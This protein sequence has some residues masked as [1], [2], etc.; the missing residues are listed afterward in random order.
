MSLSGMTLF[1]LSRRPPTIITVCHAIILYCILDDNVYP[2]SSVLLR[3]S[4]ELNELNG[5][6][7]SQCQT[8]SSATFNSFRIM[9]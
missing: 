2:E 4:T 1:E 7:Q 5:Y 8:A 9:A 6:D 3:V